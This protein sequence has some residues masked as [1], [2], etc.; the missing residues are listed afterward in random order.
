[1]GRLQIL[2]WYVYGLLW[3]KQMRKKGES[4]GRCKWV[5]DRESLK[6]NQGWLGI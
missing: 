3:E 5:Y 4:D 1:M 2:F 6:Q